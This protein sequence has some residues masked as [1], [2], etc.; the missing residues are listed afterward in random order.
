MISN[1]LNSNEFNPYYKLYIDNA[2][3][4]NIIE[5]LNQN[6]KSVVSFYNSI[7]ESK[8]DYSYAEG[9]WTVK[10]VLLHIID[11]ERIFTYR[12][13]RIARQDTTPLPGYEQD[14]FAVTAKA[15]KRSLESILDEYK[16]V[17]QASIALFNSFDVEALAQIG[18]ASGSPISVRAIAYILTGHENHHNQVI[19]ERY[20]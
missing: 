10:D 2:T 11:T 8:H 14:D 4:V 19:T 5:G 6:L 12:A 13:L 1:G 7:P 17:R 20:F 15:S 16:A 3:D 9:K 18:E